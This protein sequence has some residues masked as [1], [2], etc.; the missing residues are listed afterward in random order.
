MNT[1]LKV[2]VLAVW[3]LGFVSYVFLR[4]Q[5]LANAAMGRAAFMNAAGDR[6]DHQ[7]ANRSSAITGIMASVLIVAVL[8]VLYEAVVWVSEKIIAVVE[9]IDRQRT[10]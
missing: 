3:L 9:R 5:E 6:W 2:R 7:M 4:R 1:A 10:G 8:V